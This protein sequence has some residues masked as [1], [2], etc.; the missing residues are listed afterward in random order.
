MRQLLFRI[1]LFHDQFF[2]RNDLSDLSKAISTLIATNANLEIKNR[3]NLS[4]LRQELVDCIKDATE[5]SGRAERRY[6]EAA[7]R[8]RG[9]Q[10][11][12]KETKRLRSAVSVFSNAVE[13]TQNDQRFLKKLYFTSIFTRHRT[14]EIAHQDTFQ[15][16]FKDTVSGPPPCD[17]TFR[18]WLRTQS[19]VFWIQGKPGSGKS[20]LMKFLTQ[21]EDTQKHLKA[22]A[23]A[24]KLVVGKFYFWN[25]RTELQKSQEGLLRAIIFDILRNCPELISVTRASIREAADCFEEDGE[26]LGRDNLLR[27]YETVVTQVEFPVKFCFFV[28]GLDEFQEE[29]RTH[30]D[31]LRTLRDMKHSSDIKLCVSSRPWTVFSDEFGFNSEWSLKVEDLTRG[32]IIRY[33]TDKFNEH[34]QFHVL[35]AMHTEYS[36][37]IQQV[38]AR[39][40]GVFLWVYLV[41]RTLL[42][43]FTYHD[44]LAMTRQRLESFPPDLEDFFQHLLDSVPEIYKIQ[45]ARTL[46]LAFQVNEPL[47]GPFC[48]FLDDGD[49]DPDFSLKLHRREMHP[50]EMLNRMNVLRRR[51]DGR[52]KGLLELHKNPLRDFR[53]FV[54]ESPQVQCYIKQGLASGDKISIRACHAALA[55]LKTMPSKFHRQRIW[56]E[57]IVDLLSFFVSQAVAHGASYESL[58][59]VLHS[60]HD[61]YCSVEGKEGRHFTYKFAR[62]GYYP[63]L[64]DKLPAKLDVESSCL[65]RSSL[66]PILNHVLYPPTPSFP[67]SQ[68]S[69]E[70][71]LVR[72]ANPNENLDLSLSGYSPWVMFVGT[73]HSVVTDDNRDAM[74]N[75]TLA[76]I[77][78][79]ADLSATVAR[80]ISPRQPWPPELPDG[81]AMVESQ[82]TRDSMSQDATALSTLRVVFPAPDMIEALSSSK[83][84][85]TARQKMKERVKIGMTHLSR[86]WILEGKS[87]GSSKIYSPTTT[88]KRKQRLKE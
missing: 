85:I 77:R 70:L 34:P 15:W 64:R 43:G 49:D 42:E 47:L 4:I 13:T 9:G 3:V 30:A 32:D 35:A 69:V 74:H 62:I 46:Q 68:E 87:S 67:I 63:Y 18:E 24:K 88:N 20:T 5:I 52:S 11:E 73:L 33:V 31:L 22:W 36:S 41:V 51:L 21:A 72:G 58:R 28:D 61:I 79:G 60:A 1:A 14:I 55:I 19:G 76:L 82:P 53:D 25:S 2:Y 44:S 40:Q 50:N 48:S 83:T 57:Y 54:H 84:S 16:M 12:P 17:I 10:N 80:L 56:F 39:A 59:E 71:L 78:H 86:Q 81:S 7:L 6:L 38:A 45:L 26:A 65:V 75:V 23:G 8:D 66:S 27:I 37:L 29:R